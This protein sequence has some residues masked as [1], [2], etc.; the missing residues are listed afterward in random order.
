MDI[1]W[2]LIPL[3]LLIWFWKDALAARER[4]LMVSQRA[5]REQGVQFLD[6][7]VSLHAIR[8][9]WTG[10]GLALWRCFTFEYSL[11]SVD[12]QT[13]DLDML[14]WEVIRINLHLPVPVEDPDPPET[15]QPLPPRIEGSPSGQVVDLE[16]F[17]RQRHRGKDGAA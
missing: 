3:L 6:Q 16:A 17:R 12:R 5:C 11:E 1:P 4:A 9:R 8:L 15:Q 14:G 10:Q 13:G 7:T 2:L